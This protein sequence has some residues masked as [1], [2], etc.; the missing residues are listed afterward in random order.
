[1]P[2]NTIKLKLKF[3]EASGCVRHPWL[4]YLKGVTSFFYILGKSQPRQQFWPC[5]HTEVH[6]SIINTYSCL[7]PLNLEKKSFVSFIDCSRLSL[8]GWFS[9]IQNIFFLNCC[10][11]IQILN[12]VGWSPR[13]TMVGYSKSQ[14]LSPCE[15]D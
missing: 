13:K 9:M 3:L 4:R 14:R 5:V 2:W 6:T 15:S 11:Y 12:Q 8:L 7:I 10:R 1:M